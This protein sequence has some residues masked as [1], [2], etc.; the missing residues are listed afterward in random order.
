MNLF[1]RISLNRLRTRL[2]PITGDNPLAERFVGSLDSIEI[3]KEFPLSRVLS[4]E[5]EPELEVLEAFCAKV[6]DGFALFLS[7][8]D[9]A[10]SGGIGEGDFQSVC[11]LE[12]TSKFKNNLSEDD[13]FLDMVLS[14]EPLQ[15]SARIVDEIPIDDEPS[16]VGGRQL[17]F[18]IAK[19]ALA[20]S[21]EAAR[22]SFLIGGEFGN[23]TQSVV[24]EEDL[25]AVGAER[26]FVLPDDAAFGS[27]QDLKQVIDS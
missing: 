22:A 17:E 18:Q 8:N 15:L 19:R 3:D 16:D 2:V 4:D 11:F 21:H 5:F 25:D 13:L 26:L 10:L 14:Q 6:A 20:N 12:S 23:S 24:L 1:P 27:F 7:D 9:E